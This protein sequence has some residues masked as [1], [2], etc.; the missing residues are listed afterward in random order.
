MLCTASG[1]LDRRLATDSDFL[2][3]AWV[4]AAF[5]GG[6]MIGASCFGLGTKLLRAYGLLNVPDR[7]SDSLSS[8]KELVDPW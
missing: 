4:D 2:T 3:D 1:L 8:S 7:I 5:G 6:I